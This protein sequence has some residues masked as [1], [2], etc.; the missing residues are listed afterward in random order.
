MK[1]HLVFSMTY[2]SRAIL[3][4]EINPSW[5]E[6]VQEQHRVNYRKLVAE[7]E[8]ELGAHDFE[9]KL[10]NFKELG[11]APFSIVAHYTA[12]FRQS[13]Y[14]FIHG[15]YYA[16]LTSVCALGERIFNH[17]ILDL[18]ENYKHK[19]TYPKVSRK[20]S[21]CDWYTA[22]DVL[23]EW[24]V[25]IHVDVEPGFRKLA[26]IR[27]RSI[28]YNSA[29]YSSLRDDALLA[30]NTLSRIINMQFGTFENKW[31]I[32]GTIGHFF[33]N[34]EAEDNPF[35]KH[36][37]LPQSPL[38][39]PLFSVNLVQGQWLFFDYKDY[40]DSTLTDEEFRQQYNSRGNDNLV[41]SRLPAEDDV[42]IQQIVLCPIKH[43]V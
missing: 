38:V 29:T 43:G 31:L 7:L 18:R 23:A 16:A 20:N 1:R 4:E 8:Y 42:V 14:A 33:L 32:D 36:Y 12:W 41:P 17:L 26:D 9:Q 6:T 11:P 37:F 28:H 3:L 13:R 34:K 15:F 35:I 39:G 5:E 19:R 2:D 10:T 25:F 40:G 22:I 27:H 21:F 24:R 30:L